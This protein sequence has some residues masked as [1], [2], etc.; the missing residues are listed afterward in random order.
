MTASTKTLLETP[1]VIIGGGI[2]G[3]AAAY[4][5][6]AQ[7]VPYILL[8]SSQRFG[9]KIRTEYIPNP[10]GEGRFVVEVGP[11]SVLTQKP[12]AVNL[13]KELGLAGQLLGTNDAMR[14]TYV[15]RNG[16]LVPLPDGVF[17]IVPT[18]IWPFIRTPLFSWR[19]K[20][21][22]ALDWFIPPRQDEDDESLADFVCRRLGAEV[23]DRLAEP[24]MAGIHN[25][26]AENQSLLA[27]FPRFRQLEKQYG[28]LI[29]GMLAACRKAPTTDKRRSVFTSFRDGM[30][31]LVDALLEQLNGDL[32]LNVAASGI[33]WAENGGFDIRLSGGETLSASAIVLATPAYTAADLLRDVAPQV[34][35]QLTTIR[36]VSTG[37]VSVAYPL[38]DIPRPLDGFGLV[39]PHSENR[40]INAITWTST[41]FHHRAPEGYGLLRV[42]FGGSRHPEIMALDDEQIF[43]IVQE[44]LRDIMGITTQPLF[45]RLYRWSRANPQYD[46]GHLERLSTIEQLLP[47]GIYLAGSAYHGVGVPDCV[48]QGRDAAGKLAQRVSLLTTS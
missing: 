22:M 11:D 12:W 14:R 6:Q 36:Y 41:K 15:L 46:V 17:L 32:H 47:D 9:G 27:T 25:A 23:L 2:A 44:E 24:L 43:A 5:L 19:G 20:L 26:E 28:S 30:Q 33:S 21:R 13:A 29:R 18:R 35:E 48:K 4:E 37:T 1:V 7:G 42:F 8:E 38:A 39:I 3:L 45:S 40:R 16:R 10:A 31:T 34:S